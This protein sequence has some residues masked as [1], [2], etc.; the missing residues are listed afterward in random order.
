M[1]TTLKDKRVTQ[2]Q[3]GECAAAS[4][5]FSRFIDIVAWPVRKFSR[6]RKFQKSC[7]EHGDVKGKLG[8]VS[9]QRCRK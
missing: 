3:E 8:V 2:K 9:E 5:H 6:R 4:G 7:D 1:F